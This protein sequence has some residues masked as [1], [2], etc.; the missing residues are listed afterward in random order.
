VKF[1]DFMD[2]AK[3]RQKNLWEGERLQKDWRRK[4]P[5]HK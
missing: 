3:K 4:T 5:Q 1:D 2:N